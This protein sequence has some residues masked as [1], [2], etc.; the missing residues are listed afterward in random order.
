MMVR[1]ERMYRVEEVELEGVGARGPAPLG[2]T[3]TSCGRYYKFDVKVTLRRDARRRG[4][5]G[6]AASPRRSEVAREHHRSRPQDHAR[7][8]CRS[9]CS[10]PTGS[11]CWR[12][13]A[14]RPA[15]PPTR[16]PSRAARD[17]ASARLTPQAG[18]DRLRGRLRRDRPPRQ[19]DPADVDM[20]SLLVQLDAAAK[21]TGSTS[22]RSPRASAPRGDVAATPPAAPP[23]RGDGPH[24]PPRPA[25]RRPRAR[26]AQLPRRRAMPSTART[27]AQREQGR[28]ASTPRLRPRP[29]TAACPS[30]AAPRRPPAADGTTT[31]RPG[32]TRCRSSSSSRR[33][34]RPRRLLAR[35]QAL[36]R[37]VAQRRHRPRPP[38]HDRRHR[39]SRASRTPSRAIKAAVDR[40]RLPL[41]DGPGRDRRRDSGGPRAGP[42]ATPRPTTSA[43][44]SR[45]DPDR[46]GEPAS[47]EQLPARTS[48]TTSA[49]SASGRWRWCC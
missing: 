40:D 48:G 6:Q 17:A 3:I 26:P 23:A 31:P 37:V 18:P 39:A 25:A 44:A 12:P 34:L 19:G 42:P 21:G 10:R 35:H 11:S 13:S 29:A 14:R 5:R 38:D 16:S 41:S 33:L 1:L 7:C 45:P 30:A 32:S 20:P 15:R 4:A 43:P 9:S 36:R 22:P 47:H 2:A 24:G 27:S 8:S 49:R 28:P 46:D